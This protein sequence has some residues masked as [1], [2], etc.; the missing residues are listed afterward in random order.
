MKNIK[1]IVTDLDSTLL[2]KNKTVS[3]YTESVFSKCR[4]RGLLIVFATARPERATRQWQINPSYVIANN[5]AVITQGGK[6]LQSIIIPEA[7][8]HGVLQRFIN[9]EH[10]TGL[11]A[12][13][14]SVVYAGEKVVSTW[15]DT[16]GFTGWNPVFHSFLE[17]VTEDVCKISV[18][19]S[20]TG[21]VLGVLKDYPELRVFPNNGEH[22]H[23]ITHKSASKFN[24]VSYLSDITGIAL[25]DILAFGDDFNDVEM[26]EKCGVGVAVENAVADAKKAADFICD[27]ND[28]DGVAKYIDEHIL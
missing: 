28:N 18:E 17:P 2:R 24:A 3:E 7:V 8:K 20:D 9:D 25:S 15:P 10:V 12:E 5:G 21:I 4:E 11:C 6:D 19:C 13:T 26:L 1:M 16:I 27:T 23:Q 22:W 14:G